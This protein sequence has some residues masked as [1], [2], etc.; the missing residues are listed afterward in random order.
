MLR[1][2]DWLSL[3]AALAALL[4]LALQVPAHSSVAQ[5][6]DAV[7]SNPGGET[8][9]QQQ[10]V[11]KID[12]SRDI[13]P[14]FRRGCY[15]CHAGD[16]QQGG[17]RLD[18]RKRAMQG[19]DGG[20]VLTPG[21]SAESRLLRA[22]AGL[23]ED[24]GRMPPEGEG[25]PLTAPQIE[26]L[27]AWIDQG[28]VWPDGDD[29]AAGSRH[30]AFQPLATPPL[31]GFADSI[32]KS[33]LGERHK[34]RPEAVRNP[35]D[36]FVRTRLAAQG[37]APSPPADR[38]T[39]VRRL[40]FDLLGLPAPPEAVQEFVDD[41]S[42]DAYERLVERLLASP[43]YGERWG[44]YWLDLARYADSDGYEKDRPRPHAWR[45]RNWVIESLNADTPF[46]RFSVA[47]LAG[48]LLPDA[49]AAE[50]IAAG[51]HRN[52]L[53]NTEG[54]TDQEEDRV[55]KTVDRTNTFG[56]I[57]LGL[58]VGCAQCHS[59]KYDPI[60][61]REYYSLYAYFNSLDEADPKV[62]RPDELRLYEQARRAHQEARRPLAEALRDYEQTGLVEAQKQWEQSFEAPRHV[63][64]PLAAAVPKSL[65][66]AQFKSLP[67]GSWLASGKNADSDVY[68]LE[69]TVEPDSALHTITGI[70]LEVLPDDSLPKQGPGRAENGNFV[71]RAIRLQLLRPTA[72]EAAQNENKTPAASADDVPLA[73]ARADFSQQD[74]AVT[75][76][77]QPEMTTGWAI[78]P[79]MG[80][81]HVA[82]FEPAAALTVS[83]GTRLVITL[84]QTYTGKA[85][86]LG[87]FR[88]M[89][90]DAPR[91]VPLESVP[92]EIAATLQLAP[93]QRTPAQRDQLT[94]WYRPQDAEWQRLQHVVEE[95]DR[96]APQPPAG[97]EVQT[98]VERKQRRE[99]KI[100]IRGNFLDPGESVEPGVPAVLPA[101]P[102]RNAVADEPDRLVLARW[103]F[104]EGNPL[105][106][107]VTVN[108]IWQRFFGRGISRSLDDLG[109]QGEP[110]THPELLDWLAC[111]LIRG[112]W[113]L[114]HVQ[115]VIVNSA[116]YRQSSQVRPELLDVDPENTLLARQTRR[117]AEAEVIRDLALSVS[118]LLDPRLGGMSVRPAQP[119][120][121]AQLTYANSAKWTTSSGG[122]RYRRGLYTFFQ[123]TSPYP[124]LMI[125]DSPDSTECTAE[126][127]VSNTPIQALTL[128]NDPVFF[129][130]AQHF[131][132][133]VLREVP[134]DENSQSTL[135]RRARRAFRLTLSRE[136]SPDE[137]DAVVALYGDQ[138]Q[139]LQDQPQA[140]AQIAGQVPPPAGCTATE[141]ACWVIVGRTMMNLD[142]FITR[143]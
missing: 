95:H 131:G 8:Q 49:G 67:D 6:P 86:N 53:H 28:A 10:G 92:V 142:E 112:D 7:L 64:R 129:E 36:L 46:D 111:E 25:T 90:T 122:D 23:D 15:S 62:A 110:P 58:T 123:R 74:C 139:L 85:H 87:R 54:G 19:G 133:R 115:R 29:A 100:H 63:W 65:H 41:V 3:P 72:A 68:T 143:E 55:K 38:V 47:Q 35:I 121:Y 61:Q 141:L 103:L 56:S 9:G 57:W 120:E 130:A 76:A 97:F 134:G 89:V 84:D 42:S 16:E 79:Q 12:F 71:L 33:E 11:Q 126:R 26:M 116:T 5:Q 113:S 13:Q 128:W 44:R 59:H 1:L 20:A 27:R 93:D 96:Q 31:G 124:M 43:H 34:A 39:L 91:P 119:T 24:L 99:T 60:S 80:R 14:L 132:A 140:A 52:T 117:R 118:G 109:S 106:S 4:G 18:S 81:R 2:P 73:A 17:L 40:Y 137:L 66:G 77:I 83:A 78:S 94:A 48:D 22:V 51:F 98:V 50:R 32:A 75:A 136:P 135:L 70:R 30:W 104:R 102:D 125:F 88:L 101:V 45:Y 82:V 21:K 108:R 69:C 105:T 107:R 114:K 37:V 127:V 138:R